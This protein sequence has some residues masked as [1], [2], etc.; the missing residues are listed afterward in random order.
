MQD[1]DSNSTRHHITPL[2]TNVSG[3]SV[4]RSKNTVKMVGSFYTVL[5]LDCS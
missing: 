4:Q 1:P 5:G 2:L 3:D